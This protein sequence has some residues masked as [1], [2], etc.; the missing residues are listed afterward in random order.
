MNIK[1]LL[2]CIL[3]CAFFGSAVA[4]NDSITYAKANL[5]AANPRPET[6]HN[7]LVSISKKNKDLV[8][9]E[10]NGEKYVLTVSLKTDTTYYYNNSKGFYNT[11]DYPVWVTAIPYI[12]QTCQAYTY[13]TV[14]EKKQRMFQLLG[15]PPNGKQ[16]YFIEFWVKPENLQRPCPDNG[17][18]DT[19]CGLKLPKKVTPEYRKWFNE[20]RAIQYTI[21]NGRYPGY[22]WTQLGYTY[23]WNPENK[24]H[25]GMSEFVIPEKT[26]CIRGKIYT[27]EEYCSKN[28]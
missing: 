13:P 3:L 8:W 14:E 18:K 15:M 23:D 20:T 1:T 11:T 5:D 26:D 9:K 21:P 24:S 22:P 4:Q 7:G 12:Q 17:I 19:K 25:V 2:T 16:N 6:I 27:V 10:F 28:K